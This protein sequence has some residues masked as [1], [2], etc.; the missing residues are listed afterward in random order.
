M[1]VGGAERLYALLSLSLTREFW[2]HIQK[3]CLPIV[4]TFAPDQCL[5]PRGV[6]VCLFHVAQ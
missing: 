2:S 5:F 6:C 1:L 3:N 4:Y